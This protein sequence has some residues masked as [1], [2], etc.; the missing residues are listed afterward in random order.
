MKS[1]V[2]IEELICAK[3]QL[4]WNTFFFFL[5][6]LS[7]RYV[8]GIT[9]KTVDTYV[10]SWKHFIRTGRKKYVLRKKCFLI[11]L[12]NVLKIETANIVFWYTLRANFK[13]NFITNNNVSSHVFCS[14]ISQ[15]C[16]VFV[17]SLCGYRWTT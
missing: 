4:F 5:I 13:L 16:V 15:K 2:H 14:W 7:I 9:F 10:Q 1:V 8:H 12:E 17:F 3:S 11:S 6:V